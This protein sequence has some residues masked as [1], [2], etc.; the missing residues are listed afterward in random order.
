MSTRSETSLKAR[1]ATGAFLVTVETW[2]GQLLQL[3]IFIVLSRLLGPEAYGLMGI[4]V[5][6]NVCAD[7]LITG[8]GWGDAL[9]QRRDLGEAH[10]SSLFWV[11]LGG[12]ALLAV[13]VALSAGPTAGLFGV[14]ELAGLMPWLAL[15]LPLGSL[16]IVPDALLRREM[17][18][19]PLVARNLMALAFAGCVAV[20][21]ATAGLGVW[22]LV[23]FQLVQPA[24]A[25]AVLWAATGWR[26]SAAVSFDAVRDLL[27][28]ALNSLGDRAV[29]V[30]DV[31][32]LR[33]VIA[34]ALGPVALG[35][36]TFARKIFELVVQLVGRPV[37]RIMLPSASRL[38][39]DPRR[40][41]ELVG[42]AAE[43]MGLV[44]FPIAGGIAVTAPDLVPLVFGDAWTPA[45]PLLQAL[46]LVAA[47]APFNQLTAS[48]LFASGAAG[49]QLALTAF[50]TATLAA[51][52]AIGGMAGLD[53]VA[54]ALVART[55]V[56]LAARLVVAGRVAGIDL[57][58]TAARALR[59]LVPAGAMIVAV[60]LCRE[61]MPA[62][63]HGFTRLALSI[64]LGIVVYTAAV[65]L[66]ARG[67]ASNAIAVARLLRR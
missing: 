39:D 3:G 29:K 54:I 41:R 2:A 61:A 47:V 53:D 12:S 16:A 22:S 52:L 8:G 7:I 6:V 11:L 45:V 13:L 58:G 35:F 56:V 18:F 15:Q 28:Y 5:L 4:A 50:G 20:A 31:V 40:R 51:L 36:F 1:V 10:E 9:V 63:P 60:A 66:V 37:S 24:V 48:V 43:L 57:R 14:A 64:S 21:M 33:S 44:V 46:M 55:I 30:G 38:A 19:A 62:G 23:A 49:W 42:S 17:R 25:T 65:S 34:L 32:L 59:P 27:P 26:P 67:A